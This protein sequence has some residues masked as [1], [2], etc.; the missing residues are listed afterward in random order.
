MAGL[1]SFGRSKSCLTNIFKEVV[2]VID[3]GRVVDVVYIEFSKAFYKIKQLI[4]NG[5]LIQKFKMHEIHDLVVRIHYYPVFFR[6]E[7]CEE[8][9]SYD[10]SWTLVCDYKCMHLEINVLKRVQEVYENDLRNEWVNL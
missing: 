7:I 2:K 8:W 3:E 4:I 1:Q 5:R 6:L 10:L 9:C